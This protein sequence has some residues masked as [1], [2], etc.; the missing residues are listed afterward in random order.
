MED[1]T[2]ADLDHARKLAEETGADGIML[3]RAVFGNPWF[4]SEHVPKK[5]EKLRV[6]VEHTKLFEELF[7]KDSIGVKEKGW[8]PKNFS[9][10]KKHFKAYVTGFDGAKELRMQLMESD[11][12]NEVEQ[13]ISEYLGK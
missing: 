1:P 6:L 2:D 9:V 13:I 11:S 10:M 8:V 12:A 7:G 4:F 3:G 5:E